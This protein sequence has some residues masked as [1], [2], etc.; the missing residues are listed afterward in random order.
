MASRFFFNGRLHTTPI[1]VSAVDDTAMAPQNPA[2]GNNM[3]IIGMSD[4]GQPQKAITFSTPREAETVLRGGELLVAVRKAFSPSP[5]TNGP[6]KVTVVR[7]DPATQSSLTLLDAGGND[8]IVLTSELYGIYAN[9]IRVEVTEGS[10][11]GYKLTTRLQQTFYVADNVA[12]E[13]F[14]IRYTGAASAA[15]VTVTATQ[16]RLRTPAPSLVLSNP[17]SVSSGA[18]VTFTRTAAVQARTSTTRLE[19]PT[20]GLYAG[21]GVTG[22]NVPANTTIVAVVDHNTVTLSAAPT[23]ELPAAQVL[24]FTTTATTTAA[25]TNSTTLALDAASVSVGMTA[26]A[27]GIPGSTTVASVNGGTITINLNDTPT[28]QHVVDRINSQAGWTA[29]LSL[30]SALFTANRGLDGLIAVD[31]KN[32][33]VEVRADLQACIDYFNSNAEGFVRAERPLSATLPPD[34]FSGSKYLSGALALAPN[35]GDW[36]NAFDVLTNEDVQHVVP[37]SASVAVHMAADAHVSFMSDAGRKE[38]RAYVGPA[39][40]LSVDQVKLLSHAIASDRTAMCWPGHFD[41][42]RVTGVRTLLP[43]YMTAV[44]VAGG[45]AGLNPGNAMT[46][47]P[48]RA[49]GL[50]V[51]PSFPADTDT[52]I[53]NGICT[54]ENTPRGIKVCR[55]VSTWLANDNYNRV[56]ISCGIATDYMVRAV[57]EA[58]EPLVGSKASP[59][60]MAR[61]AA[62]TESVLTGLA[63]PEPSGPGVIVGDE[64]SPAFRNIQCE[65]EADILRVSFEASPVIP[66]NFIAIAVSVVP[67]RGTLRV[68]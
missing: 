67:Y 23:A 33:D 1:A 7:V 15:D 44:L 68:G 11:F 29:V 46:N 27:T 3:A 45:F 19:V 22:T 20:T 18:T 12:R 65:I 28:F 6:N 66:L 31:A 50:E 63:R 5:Q 41:T 48:I 51:N 34:T 49:S 30:G 57:R 32:S 42:D 9:M 16:V 54:L 59:Q 56:E 64:N 4:A 39:S 2:V 53:M 40:G 35:P 14:T 10:D 58:L 24:T 47:K 37:L 55:S 60:I 43:P 13:A 38:R 25:S 17:A 36:I 8:S 61:A 21:M 26:T 52:L 62:I